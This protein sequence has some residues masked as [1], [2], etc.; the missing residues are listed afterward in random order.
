MSTLEDAQRCLQ[1]IVDYFLECEPKPVYWDKN[2]KTE[3]NSSSFNS[4][5]MISYDF[6]KEVEKKYSQ[7]SSQNIDKDIY[8]KS[9]HFF[10][11]EKM[12]E[13]FDSEKSKEDISIQSCTDI[14]K[15][16]DMHQSDQS[17]EETEIQ[18]KFDSGKSDT[19]KECEGRHLS[20][21]HLYPVKSCAAFKVK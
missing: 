15:S 20:E 16:C 14:V 11:K 12:D 13:K 1:F 3:Y 19:F 2:R 4:Q 9:E 6:G 10:Q 17:A 18:S 5:N 8:E 21:I 7:E